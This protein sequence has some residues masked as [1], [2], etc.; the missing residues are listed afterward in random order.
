MLSS[1]GVG[2]QRVDVPEATARQSRELA[3]TLVRAVG[4]GRYLVGAIEVSLRA[5]VGLSTA[6]WD[7]TEVAELVRRASLSARHAV[8]AGNTG[9]RWDGDQGALTA[10]DLALLG[11]LRLAP[12][13]GELSL[14]PTSRRWPGPPSRPSA[15]EALL[16]W[17]SPVHGWVSPGQFIPLA[18]RTGLIDRLTEWVVQEALD[19]QC[20]WRESGLDLPVSV[21]VSAKSLPM[22]DLS[23]WILDQ[24]A[25]RDLPASCLTVEVTETA[26]ADP[27]QAAWRYSARC[28]TTASGSRST[29]SAPGSP[30]WPPCPRCPWTSSRWTSASSCAPPPRRPTRPS[31]ARWGSSAHRLGLEVV[32]EGVET[33]EIAALLGDMGIDLLQGFHFAK[34]L[35]EDELLEFVAGTALAGHVGPAAASTVPG[36]MII[37]EPVEGVDH[38]T[39]HHTDHFPV[40]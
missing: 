15:V 29:T 28:T 13:R 6:P 8:G 7:G 2:P 31:C 16:R 17:N 20:R 30:R 39:D 10:D 38:H 5:H 33:G 35:P 9:A 11:D 21:N 22:P 3:D 37:R 34:P 36:R 32:A 25:V 24:L 18:E 1:P 12:E 19:A 14:R 26:V 23:T 4:A 40:G 27:E